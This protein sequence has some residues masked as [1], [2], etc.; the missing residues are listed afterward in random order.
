MSDMPNIDQRLA[1]LLERHEAMAESLEILTRDVHAMQDN[2]KA[3]ATTMQVT[4]AR[5][6]V[7]RHAIIEAIRAYIEALDSNGEGDKQ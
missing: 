4:D 3:M 6:R 1:R 7:G 5:E 2:L